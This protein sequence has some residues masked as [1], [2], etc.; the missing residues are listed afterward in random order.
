MNFLARTWVGEW[1]EGLGRIALLA[2]EALGSLFRFR[3]A[4]PDL[5]YQVYFIGVKSQMV[6]LITGAFTGMVL[7]AQTALQFHKVK[8]DTATLAAVSVAMCSELGP[9]LTGLM[10]AGRVGAA[11]TA[12]IGTMKVTEQ[13]DALRT[14]ATHPVDYLVVPRIV[15]GLF[16]MPL[17]TAEAI[18]LGIAAGYAVSVYYYGIDPT[19]LWA[20]MLKHTADSDVAIGLIKGIIYGGIVALVGCYKGMTC[21]E[22]AEGVGRATTEAVVYSS[23]AILIANFFLTLSLGALFNGV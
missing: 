17:L 6:V 16:V 23:I 3:I 7:A 4:W 8:M 18:F 15:A 19:Y 21:G 22:G 14:L 2:K 10:V 11:I 9:V 20:N 1:L 12:E 13:I 5:L